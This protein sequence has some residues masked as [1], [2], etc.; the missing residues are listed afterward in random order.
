MK[1]LFSSFFIILLTASFLMGQ[2]FQVTNMGGYVVEAPKFAIANGNAYL[3][4]ATNTRLYKFPVTG[5]QSP[6]SNPI[7]FDPTFWGPSAVDISSYGNNVYTIT[8][9]FKS[10]VWVA[11]IGYS[12]NGGLDWTNYIVDT[13][14]R[15]NWIPGRA[16]LPKVIV[17]EQGIPYFFYYVFE[18]SRDTSGLYLYT[19]GSHKKIDLNIPR[20]RYEY[21]IAPFVV[22]Q[23]NVD[24]LFVAYYID[25][26]YYFVHSTDMGNTFSQPRKIQTF[27]VMW[28]SDNWKPNFQIDNSGK[29]YFYYSY[30]DFGQPGQPPEHKMYH[31]VTTST[32]WGLTWSEPVQ[33]DTNFY[34]IDFRVV[35]D[36]FIKSYIDMDNNIYL[37]SSV[38]LINWSDRDRVNTVDSSV[39]GGFE[40]EIYTNKLAFAWRDKRTGNDEIFYRLMEIPT[41]VKE[42]IIPANFTLYQN[43]PNPFNPVT[44]ISF[45][46]ARKARTT[47]S[48]YDIFG[49]LVREIVNEELEPGKY[50]IEFNGSSLSSGVYYYQLRSGNF[51]ETKKMILIK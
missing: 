47:L 28:P 50:N 25:S 31:L 18:N 16:D 39:S 44:T 38:D 12:T 29:L 8:Y 40:T 35:Q 30:M 9:D 42:N 19:F 51:S 37:H 17:S 43:Y 23:N 21:G 22:T 10:T 34:D 11:K 24:H 13:L 20:A 2:D 7:N 1:N 48:I 27:W 36:K 32:D 49:K 33:I 6:I 14:T 4:F 3:T 26:S 5:P 46:L 15:G 45:E 41:N